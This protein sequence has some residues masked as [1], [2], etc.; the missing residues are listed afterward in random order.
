MVDHLNDI[1]INE[2][3]ETKKSLQKDFN[4]NKLDS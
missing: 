4:K 1:S 3:E 2:I